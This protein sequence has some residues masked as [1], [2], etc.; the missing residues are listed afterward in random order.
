[1]NKLNILHVSYSL[2]ESSAA[3]RLAKSLDERVNNYFLCAR[4]ST[5]KFIKKNS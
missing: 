5:D 4:I 2:G 3:T 1:M